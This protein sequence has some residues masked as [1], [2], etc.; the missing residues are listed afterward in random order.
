MEGAERP[1]ERPSGRLGFD[2]TGR[3]ELT[4][5]V[6]HVI[7]WVAYFVLRTS[8]AASDRPPDPSYADF[9]FMLNRGLVVGTYFALTACLLVIAGVFGAKRSGARRRLFLLFGAIALSPLAQM[10]EEGWPSVLWPG[11]PES[12]AMT[13][14]AVVYFFQYGWALALWGLMQ[15]LLDYHFEAVAQARAVMR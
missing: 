7:F 1:Q 14:P 6:A 11:M 12:E 9:P 15:A 8:A 3:P 5:W 4:R 13:W 2:L 10:G